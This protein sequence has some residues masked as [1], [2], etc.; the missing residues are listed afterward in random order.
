MMFWNVIVA[1]FILH[2]TCVKSSRASL[3]RLL[4]DPTLE[5]VNV[6]EALT[7]RYRCEHP[8]LALFLRIC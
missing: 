1:F 7:G 8:K 2:N 5:S 4:V 3:A 6:T